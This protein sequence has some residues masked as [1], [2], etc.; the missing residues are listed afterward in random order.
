MVPIG[1]PPPP[2]PLSGLALY[3][4]ALVLILWAA[5]V[6]I[7]AFAAEGASDVL[8]ARL[9]SILM[10]VEAVAF[11]AASALWGVTIQRAQRAERASEENAQAAANGRKL[12][13]AV[14]RDA[15]GGGDEGSA[16]ADHTPSSMQ[17]SPSEALQRHAHL[18]KELFPAA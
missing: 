8:W 14:I 5:V 7:M 10:T 6:L 2:R 12:A 9:G 15:P 18:A 17:E 3:L 13:A 11:G 1:S 16:H 4:A